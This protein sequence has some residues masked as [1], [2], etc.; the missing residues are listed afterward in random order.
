MQGRIYKSFLFRPVFVGLGVHFTKMRSGF[1]VLFISILLL[2]S[3][4]APD[5]VQ[6]AGYQGSPDQGLYASIPICYT[7][8]PLAL[9]DTLEEVR[10][11]TAVPFENIP[12]ET[13]SYSTLEW[14]EHH[15]S[16]R[17]D[18]VLRCTFRN[19]RLVYFSCETISDESSSDSPQIKSYIEPLYSCVSEIQ[20]A[21]FSENSIHVEEKNEVFVQR[22]D[23]L[24]NQS[25]FS[26]IH[27]EIGYTEDILLLNNLLHS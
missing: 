7:L 22:F 17:T 11:K 9:G 14:Q 13:A 23:M 1:V 24:K 27:Y 15:A 12:L 8:H 18:S 2:W 4:T 19:Q 5:S 16:S 20:T 21:F 10:Q 25:R 6:L 26:G 3:C